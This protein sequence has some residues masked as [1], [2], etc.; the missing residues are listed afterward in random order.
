MSQQQLF[1]YS[2]DGPEAIA[3]SWL[4]K[5]RMVLEIAETER[6]ILSLS[7]KSRTFTDDSGIFIKVLA[8]RGHGN[9]IYIDST[10]ASEF[11]SKKDKPEREIMLHVQITVK[12]CD[13]IP[14]YRNN[15]CFIAVEPI[16]LTDTEITFHTL[17]N[18]S[19]GQVEHGA[20][21]SHTDGTLYEGENG[22]EGITNQSTLDEISDYVLSLGGWE[23]LEKEVEPFFTKE[24]SYIPD[25]QGETDLSR[26][27]ENSFW[28]SYRG[29]QNLNGN[30]FT[31]HYLFN[32]A[33]Q[34]YPNDLLVRAMFFHEPV[35]KYTFPLRVKSEVDDEYTGDEVPKVMYSTLIAASDY[36]TK[37]GGF[38]QGDVHKASNGVINSEN[39]AVDALYAE[40]ISSPLQSFKSDFCVRKG[41][42]VPLTKIGRSSTMGRHPPIITAPIDNAAGEPIRTEFNVDAALINAVFN[43]SFE[44]KDQKSLFGQYKNSG[45]DPYY[46]E[47]SG[48]KVFAKAIDTY[49]MK[50]SDFYSTRHSSAYLCP[51]MNFHWPRNLRDFLSVD[52]ESISGE[53]VQRPYGLPTS[54]MRG[55][56]QGYNYAIAPNRVVLAVRTFFANTDNATSYK[57]VRRSFDVRM[58]PWMVQLQ[59]N[60]DPAPDH[61][62]YGHRVPPQEVMFAHFDFIGDSW[63]NVWPG[64]EYDEDDWPDM[65]TADFWAHYNGDGNYEELDVETSPPLDMSKGS[66]FLTTKGDVVQVNLL[67]SIYAVSNYGRIS[68]S[69]LTLSE[70]NNLNRNDLVVKGPRDE[71]VDT[72]TLKVPWP[73]VFDGDWEYTNIYGAAATVTSRDAIEAH[74]ELFQWAEDNGLS[75]QNIIFESIG[76]NEFIHRAPYGK[77]I[78][79]DSNTVESFASTRDPVDHEGE[80]MDFPEE[81]TPESFLV[82]S[83]YRAMEREGYDIH[84]P[85]HDMRIETNL[86]DREIIRRAV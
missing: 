45:N 39:L 83:I 26:I 2:Y 9:R 84:Q 67:S 59:D 61:F 73:S 50:D 79:D 31:D 66:D 27:M 41:D 71:V 29:Q 36:L 63:F 51:R 7:S 20:D 11:T 40:I 74:Y 60:E 57:G 19:K 14:P 21:G 68:S 16:P 30:N 76:G 42:L 78:Y 10:E 86:F 13:N 4:N 56:N 6:D 3:S 33:I 12:L 54:F 18:I 64:D 58:A 55:V 82:H 47:H 43:Q 72:L 77:S 15:P 23:L 69:D 35:E 22:D 38:N 28:G 32:C 34:D 80:P 46:N 25:P 17:Y 5:A 49:Y 65:E 52:E 48:E 70:Y 24:I 44:G 85:I 53:V 1:S 37:I 62:W 8:V 75:A 81:N